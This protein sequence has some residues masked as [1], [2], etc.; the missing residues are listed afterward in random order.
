[1]FVEVKINGKKEQVEP[2]TSVKKILVSKKVRPE[3]VAVEINGQIVDRE[4][5]DVTL[6][7]EGDELEYLYYMGGGSQNPHSKHRIK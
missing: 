2:G 1:M 5:Y 4:I 3:M 7:N 6:I